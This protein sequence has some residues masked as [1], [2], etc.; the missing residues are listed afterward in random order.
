MATVQEC[1]CCQEMDSLG[2]KMAT[3]NAYTEPS[4]THAILDRYVLRTALEANMDRLRKLLEELLKNQSP[5]RHSE[6]LQTLKTITRK[7]C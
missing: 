7:V 6:R 4:T 5:E 3:F 1:V 2:N